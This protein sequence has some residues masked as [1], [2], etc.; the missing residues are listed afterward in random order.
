MANKQE[1]WEQ[2]KSLLEARIAELE[3]EVQ[4]LNAMSEARATMGAEQLAASTTRLEQAEQHLTLLIDAVVVYEIFMP[5]PLD[6]LALHSAPRAGLRVQ[7]E[8]AEA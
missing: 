3:A 8:P 7:P 1:D 5:D 2:E 6:T 4:K